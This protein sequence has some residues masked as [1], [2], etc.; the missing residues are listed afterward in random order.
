MENNSIE[1]SSSSFER[2][3]PLHNR[4]DRQQVVD[5]SIAQ[6]YVFAAEIIIHYELDF[7]ATILSHSECQA[8]LIFR[9]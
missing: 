8:T 1:S 9:I 4:I 6:F 5:Q 3:S 2:A 7:A